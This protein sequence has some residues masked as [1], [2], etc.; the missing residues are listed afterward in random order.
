MCLGGM[1]SAAQRL[2]APQPGAKF[3]EAFRPGVMLPKWSGGYLLSWEPTITASGSNNLI[4]YDR[5]GR[6]AAS[7]G[8]WFDDA[9]KVAISDVAA[10]SDGTVAAAGHAVTEAGL[11]A[12][13]VARISIPGGTKRVTRTAG[14]EG[15]AIVFGPDKTT[16][17]LGYELGDD[18][19][20]KRTTHYILKRFG[21]DGKILGELLSS[22]D[23]HCLHPLAPNRHGVAQLVAAGDRVGILSPACGEWIELTSQGKLVLREKVKRPVN[24]GS[25]DQILRRL[26]MTSNG[27]VLAS[28]GTSPFRLIRQSGE[29]QPIPSESG[30]LGWLAGAEGDSLVYEGGGGQLVS[31]SVVK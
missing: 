24:A 10:L 15:D 16:W 13:F 23:F 18:R 11:I 19:S 22:S 7:V 9:A 1:P 3:G 29:W 2:S 31:M 30:Q 8:L 12:G 17:V 25:T 27:D 4:V 5:G 6:T 28:V 21:I 14:F 20:F 26:V